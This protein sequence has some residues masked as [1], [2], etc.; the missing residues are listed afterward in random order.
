MCIKLQVDFHH[1]SKS[2]SALAISI[3]IMIAQMTQGM[4]PIAPGENPGR[5]EIMPS[6]TVKQ[7]PIM[8]A[9]NE[10]NTTGD[11]A[12]TATG[13]KDLVSEPGSG[14]E[15]DNKDPSAKSRAAPLKSFVP[16]EKIPA[17]QAVDFPVDI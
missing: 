13:T 1:P 8:L 4:G 9:E 14:P 3:F 15:T 11:K 6:S 7:K 17:E 10:E 5:T 12:Q 16:S 2:L